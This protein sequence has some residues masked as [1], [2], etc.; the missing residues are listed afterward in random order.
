[1]NWR[2]FKYSSFLYNIKASYKQFLLPFTAFQFIRTL[3]LPTSL[4]VLI[5]GFLAI[6]YAAFSMDWL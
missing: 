2:R 6:S 3:L 4:D 5:L 1:M